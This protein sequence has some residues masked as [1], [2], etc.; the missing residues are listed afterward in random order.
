MRRYQDLDAWKSGHELALQVYQATKPMEE[1]DPGLTHRIRFASVRA[2]GRIAFG[3]AFESRKRFV[4][5][6]SEALGYLHEVG[7]IIGLIRGL[8]L[9][10]DEE[11]DRLESLRGRM[12]FYTQKL[13][14][15]LLTPPA[16]DQG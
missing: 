7:W 15:S 6:V 4:L 14:E 1:R 9:L 5:A 2:V 16:E 12:T 8:Q 13:I 10:P 3:S 11:C